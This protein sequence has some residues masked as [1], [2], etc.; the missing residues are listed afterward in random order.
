MQRLLDHLKE[1]AFFSAKDLES[2]SNTLDSMQRTLSIGE[3]KYPLHLIVLLDNRLDTC[4]HLLLDLKATLADLSP[5]LTRTHEKLVSILRSISAA[6]TRAK[7]V[8][9]KIY[10]TKLLTHGPLKFPTRE[11]RAFQDELK[12]IQ[13]GM[14]DGKFLADDSSTPAGQAIVTELLARCLKWADIVLERCVESFPPSVLP[15]TFD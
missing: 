4:R 1:A 11:V 14:V 7:V 13:G 6:N 3:G 8:Y 15:L 2:L 10:I 9:L 5:E 12:K